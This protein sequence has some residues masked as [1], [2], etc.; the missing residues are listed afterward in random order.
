MKTRMGF[1]SNSSTTS[2]CIMGI[3]INSDEVKRLAKK[4]KMDTWDYFETYLE[5]NGLD[6]EME[7]QQWTVG[8]SI[9]KLGS[10]E[11]RQGFHDKVEIMLKNVIGYQFNKLEDHNV[12]II[13]GQVNS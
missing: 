4:K 2:F 13:I 12:N 11:T 10:N 1:I 3:I 5:G 9:E 7:D 8:L 6:V